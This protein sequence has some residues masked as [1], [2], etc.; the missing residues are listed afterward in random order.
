MDMT[1]L[2]PTAK[3]P[4]RRGPYPSYKA[5]QGH[6][7][8]LDD[9]NDAKAVSLDFLEYLGA[10]PEGTQGDWYVTINEGAEQGIST[11]WAAKALEIASTTCNRDIYVLMEA[12]AYGY[13][14]GTIASWVNAKAGDFYSGEECL[15]YPNCNE[16]TVTINKVGFF[17]GNIPERVG[18]DNVTYSA[19]STSP[20]SPWFES[21]VFPENPSGVIKTPQLPANRRVCDGVYVWPM[22][23]GMRDFVIPLDE[24]PD[25]DGWSYAIT[26]GYSASVRAGFITYKKE[27]EA[28]S[29]NVAK[30]VSPFHSLSY[31]SVS[32]WTWEGQMQLQQMMMSRPLDDP[33]SWVGAYNIIMKEKWEIITE[34]FEDCPVLELTNSMAGA[35]AFFVYKSPYLGLQSGT[36]TSFFMDV[37]GIR[38]TTY[39]WGFRGADPAE[40]FGEG[41]STTDFTRMQLYRDVEVYHEVARRA[42]IVCSDTSASIGDLISVDDWQTAGLAS[43]RHLKEGHDL[44]TRRRLLKDELPHLHERK[45][46]RLLSNIE[47]RELQDQKVEELCAPAYSSSCMM[48]VTG[49]GQDDIF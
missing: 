35:Y 6:E 17:P 19:T 42:K 22:Y 39:F 38:A 31:G 41:I 47:F 36:Y 24:M 49:R 3:F 48:S 44:E 37:L 11:L 32:Q 4:L 14:D 29:A 40:Y 18:G 15:C 8:A 45:L 2:T 7:D 20:T 1:G 9:S 25:C 43:R 21:L 46:E 16:P 13:S 10:I 28:F 30:I 33:T 23:F 34:A 5:A 26:K 12:P 27:S